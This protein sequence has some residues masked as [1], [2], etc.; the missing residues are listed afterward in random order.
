ML[1]SL[2]TKYSYYHNLDTILNYALLYSENNKI[3]HAS[4]D[5]E[6]WQ[7]DEAY[8]VCLSCIWKK[9]YIHLSVF[10]PNKKQT[11]RGSLIVWVFISLVFTLAS[12]GAFIFIVINF[13]KQKKIVEIK[14]DFVNNMTHEL[15]TPLSTISVASEVLLQAKES[16]DSKKVHKYSKIIFDENHRMRKLVDKVLNIATLEK[17]RLEIEPEEIDIH[18][19][20]CKTVSNFCLEACDENVKVDYDLNA[21]NPH[22]NADTLHLRNI[23]N[24]LI[25]NAIKYSEQNPEITIATE[26]IN[27]ELNIRVSDKGKGI[28]RD[29]ASK[30]FDK[31]YRVPVGNIHNVKG[32]GLGLYYVKTMMEAHGGRV[33]IMSNLHKGTR[34]DLFLPQ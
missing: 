8:K 34:I 22:V 10:F 5:F 23:F 31:F 24:N 26:N 28:P 25:D 4:E 29:A 7:E 18:A 2:L 3:L 15:K 21:Q 32:F 19:L 20:I 12:I 27:G 16:V 1:Y 14:N 30:V 17:D 13:F 6:I 11:I 33:E 9:E